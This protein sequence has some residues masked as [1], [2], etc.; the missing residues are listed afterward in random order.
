MAELIHYLTPESGAWSYVIPSELGTESIYKKIDWFASSYKTL[1]GTGD[2]DEAVN[3]MLSEIVNIHNLDGVSNIQ[4]VRELVA[5]IKRGIEIVDLKS[6]ISNIQLVKIGGQ[7]VAINGH[8]T[9]IAYMFCGAKAVT[10]VPYL[11]LGDQTTPEEFLVVF[12]HHAPKI[13]PEDWQQSVLNWA[14]ADDQQVEPRR[15]KNMGELFKA[16]ADTYQDQL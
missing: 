7:F 15:Q 14:A 13:N 6:G 5:K 1:Q 3:L 9:L 4:T 2:K 11:L 12:G 16:F 8:H 10:D